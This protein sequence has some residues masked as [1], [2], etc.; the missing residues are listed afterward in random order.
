M[1]PGHSSLPHGS[2]LDASRIIS[3]LF[4]FEPNGCQ[5][6]STIGTR[7]QTNRTSLVRSLEFLFIPSSLSSR[8]IF[9]GANGLAGEVQCRGSGS[10]IELA[11]M[12]NG[13]LGRKDLDVD[14]AAFELFDCVRIRL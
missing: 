5:R 13:I 3:L 11:I 14:S 2:R 8:P 7:S 1:Y 9:R 10:R 6:V 4:A 12:V